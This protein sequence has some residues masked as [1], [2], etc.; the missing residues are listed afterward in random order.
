[1]SEFYKSVI[2]NSY[3]LVILLLF[4]HFYSDYNQLP[5]FTLYLHC[6]VDLASRSSS[7]SK[8]KKTVQGTIP[9]A[10]TKAAASSSNTSRGKLHDRCTVIY[11]VV[12]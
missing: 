6:S 8:K 4:T 5:L 10:A 9:F 2:L 7:P 12:L 3:L 1:M 11:G